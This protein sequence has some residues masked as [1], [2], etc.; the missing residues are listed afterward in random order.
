MCSWYSLKLHDNNITPGVLMF[1]INLYNTNIDNDL[2]K[3]IPEKYKESN[4]EQNRK[5]IFR[6]S[7]FMTIELIKKLT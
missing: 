3:S 1:S 5:T 6:T 4:N 7:L 2:I